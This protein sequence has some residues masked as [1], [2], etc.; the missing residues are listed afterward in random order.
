MS[1]K[2]IR[3][4][5][6][7]SGREVSFDPAAKPGVSNLLT[8]HAALTGG[9]VETSEKA[10]TGGGYGD[11]KKAVAEVVADFTGSFRARYD[12][13]LADRAG[14][15]A[16]LAAGAERARDVASVT[17]ATVYDRVGF[18]PAAVRHDGGR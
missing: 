12:E 6:T 9:T 8:I 3:S 11:L 15:E 4:A 10:F 13:V 5:V 14:L 17:L 18:V 2:R 1:A 16:I 7:D